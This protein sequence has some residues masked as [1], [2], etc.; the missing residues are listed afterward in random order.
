MEKLTAKFFERDPLTCA[1]E[2]IGATFFWNG[3]NGRIVE[4][5]AYDSVDDPACH[6]WTRPSSRSFVERHQAGDA[7]VYLN[8]G[9]YWLFNILVKGGDRSGFVLFRAL[10]PLSGLEFMRQRRGEM[11][12]SALASGPGK[13]TRALG[14]D[15][16]SH[17]VSFLSSSHCGILQGNVVE[18]GAGPRIGISRA[19]ERHWRFGDLSSSSLSRKF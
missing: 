12:D 15:G 16:S 8:Y 4:T 11:K 19:T 3:C 10:E 1:R 17:G 9:M 7:Y 6:T 2:L 18:I 5:E 13:L 14:I